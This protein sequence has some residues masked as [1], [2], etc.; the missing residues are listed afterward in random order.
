MAKKGNDLMLSIGDKIY[1][2][3]TDCS[4]DITTD[5]TEVATTKYKH[6]N[7]AGKFKE[8]ESDINSVSLSS[9][10]V[11]AD[12]EEDYIELVNKQLAGEAIDVSYIDVTEKSAAGDKGT[13]G[14]LE[15]ATGGMKV[16]GKALITSISL[17][18]PTDGEA[19]FQVQLQGTGVW[20]VAKNS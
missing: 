5:T 1:G 4:V 10:Y 20:T 6:K 14:S 16:S 2:M 8:F 15:A 17:N 3:A 13:T 12:S 11:L 19:T 9:G 18:A 7:S